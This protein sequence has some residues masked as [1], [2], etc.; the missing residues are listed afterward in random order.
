MTEEIKSDEGR[1]KYLYD[2]IDAYNQ[3][4]SIQ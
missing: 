3:L 2:H 1:V 4:L